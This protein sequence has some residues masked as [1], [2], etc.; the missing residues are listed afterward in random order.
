MCRNVL[1][2]LSYIVFMAFGFLVFFS[3][4]GMGQQAEQTERVKVYHDYFIFLKLM[5][6][7]YTDFKRVYSNFQHSPPCSQI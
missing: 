6:L 7:N 4:D 2:D 5:G 1:H 3:L